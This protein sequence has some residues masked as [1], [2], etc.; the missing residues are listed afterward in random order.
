MTTN[1]IVMLSLLVLLIILVSVSFYLGNRQAEKDAEKERIDK[2]QKGVKDDLETISRY[3][4]RYGDKFYDVLMDFANK[5]EKLSDSDV[6]ADLKPY[7][8][9]NM[10]SLNEY[11]KGVSRLLGRIVINKNLEPRFMTSYLSTNTEDADIELEAA[12]TIGEVKELAEKCRKI[13]MDVDIEAFRKDK[14]KKAL[15][16]G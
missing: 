12:L 9:Y 13:K 10:K 15:L 7:D 4:T 16:H 3:A 2:I 8:V 5:M 6:M 11:V 1:T 14:V